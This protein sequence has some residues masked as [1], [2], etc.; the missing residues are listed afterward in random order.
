MDKTEVKDETE[1]RS[2]E[3]TE[4]KSASDE[5]SQLLLKGATILAVAG[6]VS[7]IFGGIFRIPL[8]NMIGANGVSYYT[9]A[10]NIY[11][12]LF[13]IAT[14]AFPVAISRM[15]SSR[16]AEKDY[17][18]AHRSYKLAMRFSTVLGL[19]SALLLFFGAG[20]I[21]RAYNIPGAELSIK[22]L[23][24]AILITPI[25]ASLRGYY[26]GRQ[27]MTPTAVTEVVEQMARVVVGL[28]L[29]YM[30]YKTSLEKAAA[31]ATFG[32]SAG[33]IAALLVMI[34]IYLRDRSYRASKF[35][36]SVTREE[37]DKV[38][39]KELLS[40]LIP[41]T[42]GAAILPIMYNIDS[43]IVVRRL[44]ATGWD[45]HT[46]EKLFGL[47][48]GYCDP[49]I[50][51]P[52]I[53]IDAV[54]I[55][56]MPAITT[57]FT[58]KD[59]R[60]LNSNLKTGLKTMM[61]IACPCT[62]GLIVMAK[63]I[64]TMLYFRQYDEAVLAVPTMRILALVVVTSAAMR[65]FA[66]TLNGIGKMMLPVRNLFIGVLVKGVLT[67][68]L[69]GVHAININGAPIGTVTAMLIAGVLNYFTLKKYVSLKIDIK[70]AI[71]KPLLASTI[72][73]VITLGIYKLMAMLS[74]SNLISTFIAI[75]AAVMVYF[76]SIFLT[77]T[78]S[79]EE[80]ELIPKGDLIYRIA[81]RMK[82]AR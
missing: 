63:P 53:F 26:Q 38:R 22:A 67:Y 47:M 9:V 15:V 2:E 54:S 57:A 72:M 14:A 81:V 13:T 59:D 32:A 39:F 46:A 61:I 65:I 29:A 60:G 12:L 66:T 35:A 30:F 51:L 7:K 75:L 21:A 52:N 19:A 24:P 37:S 36:E 31:G 17:I 43:A 58:L 8:T 79:R 20:F 78:M 5:A 28:A 55:S 68:S 77:G 23:A 48:G 1:I 34:V 4:V 44:I 40:F 71:L 74:G 76:V 50:N 27:Q 64:L 62:V 10:Y 82:I 69:I 42:L 49:I 70:D 11:T 73:G 6:L 56:L 16:I 18:N 45:R 33:I 41:I 80:V 3:Q 25:V